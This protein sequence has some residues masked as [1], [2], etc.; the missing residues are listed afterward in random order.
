MPRDY[1]KLSPEEELALVASGYYP[2]TGAISTADYGLSQPDD[3]LP[4]LEFI[5]ELPT[6]ESPSML[7]RIIAGINEPMNYIG[8]RA[9]PGLHQLGS[10]LY[11]AA[12]GKSASEIGRRI[13]EIDAQRQAEDQRRWNYIMG[14]PGAS[15]TPTDHIFNTLGVVIPAA[16]STKNL[17]R[18]AARKALASSAASNASMAG[19]AARTIGQ[20]NQT[21]DKMIPYARGTNFTKDDAI[22]FL[23]AAENPNGVRSAVADIMRNDDMLRSS[24]NTY[25]SIDDT[26]DMFT[27]AG[28]LDPETWVTLNNRKSGA[29]IIGDIA[30]SRQPSL[31][32]NLTSVINNAAR[33]KIIEADELARA[34]SENLPRAWRGM[35]RSELVDVARDN[36]VREAWLNRLARQDIRSIL[37]NFGR[38]Y[39]Q[40]GLLGGVG[41]AFGDITSDLP[42]NL[43]AEAKLAEIASSEPTSLKPTST[44]KAVPATPATNTTATNTNDTIDDSS[45]ETSDLYAPYQTNVVS[46]ELSYNDDGTIPVR[47]IFEGYQN[48][49]QQNTEAT[50][51][52]LEELKKNYEGLRNIQ[53]MDPYQWETR[54]L[55]ERQLLDAEKRAANSYR[56]D[57]WNKIGAIL[58]APL[59]ARRLENPFEVWERNVQG[60]VDRDPEVRRLRR[61]LGYTEDLPNGS[62]RAKSE[63][64]IIEQVS[65]VNFDLLN[66]S[67]KEH[68]AMLEAARA[69]NSDVSK[70]R[71][72]EAEARLREAQAKL[73]KAKAKYYEEGG[74]YRG[75]DITAISSLLNQGATGAYPFVEDN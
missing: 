14:E 15:L 61:L 13:N 56:D 71:K 74:G 54:V 64:S 30:V 29:D 41:N 16:S 42:Y 27:R 52:E 20:A 50:K 1:L 22:R 25:N 60:A 68:Q 19:Q 72:E 43:E 36:A 75:V 53:A 17:I 48:A 67:L 57:S 37:P 51:K 46:D 8:N 34:A 66:A 3:S 32:E 2:D 69:F 38:R 24:I 49:L 58:T 5:A 44:D 35:S 73:A 59:T 4:K 70:R 11:N 6:P 26:V 18:G 21:I 31:I 7:G 28:H 62:D 63:Q 55:L 23:Q 40:V 12:T 65:K 33:N 39:A 47:P 9:V 10:A 45:A